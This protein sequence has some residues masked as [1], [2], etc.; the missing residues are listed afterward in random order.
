MLVR[1]GLKA[2]GV[3]T[4]FVIPRMAAKSV[5][6]V[7]TLERFGTGSKVRAGNHLRQKHEQEQW[8]GG[9]THVKKVYH[10]R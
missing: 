9:S 5:Q 10:L 2:D 1:E 4:T 3:G 6:A 7:R 8:H